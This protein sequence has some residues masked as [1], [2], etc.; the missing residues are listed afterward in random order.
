MIRTAIKWIGSTCAV[1][2]FL[3]LSIG[4]FSI[5]SS[6]THEKAALGIMFLLWAL[7][8]AFGLFGPLMQKRLGHLARGCFMAGF[9]V[10]FAAQAIGTFYVDP[11]SRYRAQGDRLDWFADL[12]VFVYGVFGAWGAAAL[13]LSVSAFF[14]W[15]A[16]VAFREQASNSGAPTTSTRR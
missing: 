4:S 8:A 5:K 9:A 12:I 7:A 10:V 11:G 3:G 1:L 14:A 15:L 13:F 16:S 2:V 6:A